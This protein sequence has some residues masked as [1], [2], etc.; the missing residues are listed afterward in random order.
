MYATLRCLLFFFLFYLLDEGLHCFIEGGFEGFAGSFYKEVRT[1]N[2]HPYFSN[3]VFDRMRHIIEYQKNI[4]FNDPVVILLHLF[5]L[6]SYI[7]HELFV[8]IKVNCLNMYNH[9]I[10]VLNCEKFESK[11]FYRAGIPVQYEVKT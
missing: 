5:D 8:C 11:S 1:G 4:H 7:I 3:F 9:R 10:D 2:M 6:L